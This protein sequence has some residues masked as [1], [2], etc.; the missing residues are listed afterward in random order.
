[1]LCSHCGKTK[2]R[3]ALGYCRSCHNKYNREWRRDKL[4]HSLRPIYKKYDSFGKSIV[5]AMI[6]N[7]RMEK[8]IRAS[9]A[10]ELERLSKL[11]GFS[12][13]KDR[14]KEMAKSTRK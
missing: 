13:F 10:D 3:T 1:M 7:G 12:G 8:L 14:L 5:I 2:D 4:K 9:L 6:E 11:K